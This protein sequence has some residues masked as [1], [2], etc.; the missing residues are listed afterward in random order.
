MVLTRRTILTAPAIVASATVGIGPVGAQTPNSAPSSPDLHRYKVGDITVTAFHEGSLTIPLDPAF[1]PNAKPEAVKSALEAAFLPT[2]RL[3]LTFTT[4][5]VE[6]GRNRVLID[7]GFG[8]GGP[9]G[10]GGLYRGLA[11]A[12]IDPKTIDTVI[13]SHFHRDHIQGLRLKDGS[14]AYP[15]AQVLVNEPERAFWLDEARQNNPPAALKDNFGVVRKTFQNPET[16]GRYEW[17]KE[18][19]P[20]ITAIDASGHSPGHAAFLIS[21]GRDSLIVMSDVTNLPALFVRNPDWS[22]RFDMDADKARATRH[23][24]LDMAASERAHVAFFHASFP[25]HGFIARSG[26]GYELV[27]MQ[28]GLPG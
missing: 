18:I 7:V 2:E 4:L 27:P 26:Q 13:V 23:R 6:T 15:N 21:S 9:P 8:D 17:G 22:A 5:M 3:T 20:G 24:M 1:I 28:W 11:A 25:A 16:L 19:V 10:T 14:A 12:G